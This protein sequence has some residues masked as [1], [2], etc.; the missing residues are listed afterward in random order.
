MSFLSKLIEIFSGYGEPIAEVEMIIRPWGFIEYPQDQYICSVIYK[1]KLHLYALTALYTVKI[2]WLFLK[3]RKFYLRF[4]NSALP[5]FI[6]NNFEWINN[7]DESVPN[8]SDVSSNYYSIN[9]LSNYY[10]ISSDIYKKDIELMKSDPFHLHEWNSVGYWEMNWKPPEEMVFKIKLYKTE[11][12]FTTFNNWSPKL[13]SPK[14]ILTHYFLFLKE[15]YNRLNDEEQKIFKKLL[16]SLH[17]GL[18]RSLDSS[19]SGLQRGREVANTL[20]LQFESL[21]R[22]AGKRIKEEQNLTRN[23]IEEDN[24]KL[25]LV[26]C[27]RCDKENQYANNYCTNCGQK[28]KK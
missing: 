7:E 17:N 12:G 22:K 5:N 15:I 11:N 18:Q 16:I 25:N 19:L 24:Q 6:D 4:L 27:S 3:N 21:I 1:D 2:K 8:T 14:E 20:L 9:M 13:M 26:K 23:I 10:R 28:L